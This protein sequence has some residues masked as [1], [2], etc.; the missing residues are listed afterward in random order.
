MFLTKLLVQ[1]LNLN[2][3][4]GIAPD[5]S[6][7]QGLPSESVPDYGGLSLVCYS[8]S[9]HLIQAVPSSDQLPTDNLNAL[10]HG[11]QQ[12]LWLLFHPA[13]DSDRI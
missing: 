10:L 7:R 11:L 12:G 5:Y 6:I 13:S 4:P 3:V 1:S 9:G 8:H 2:S